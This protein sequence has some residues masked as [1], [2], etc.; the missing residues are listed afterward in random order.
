M[1]TE[2]S[3]MSSHVNDQRP[4]FTSAAI[5]SAAQSDPIGSVKWIR[6]GI[7]DTAQSDPIYI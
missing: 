7:A 1:G 2:A 4:R 5:T 6:N 3:S